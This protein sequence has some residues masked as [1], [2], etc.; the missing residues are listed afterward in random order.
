LTQH[1][2]VRRLKVEGGWYA[3]LRVPTIESDEQLAI[4]LL[5][6]TGVLVQPGHF[7]DFPVSGYLVVSLIAPQMA[8]QEG[9]GRVLSRFPDMAWT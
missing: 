9:V 8:F 3:I 5:E 4:D 6:Q 7:Y 2:T 1:S